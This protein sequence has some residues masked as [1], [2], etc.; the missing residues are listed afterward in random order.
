[1][2]KDSVAVTPPVSFY[3]TRLRLFLRKTFDDHRN[4]LRNRW[5]IDDSRRFTILLDVARIS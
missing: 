1:M 5:T 4:E 2:N 3:V